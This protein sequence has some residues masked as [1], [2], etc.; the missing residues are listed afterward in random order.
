[1]LLESI[2]EH[3][4]ATVALTDFISP[5]VHDT[6]CPNVSASSVLSLQSL[7]IGPSALSLIDFALNIVAEASAF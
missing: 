3:V 6:V 4:L 7:G 2:K 5:F 1:M